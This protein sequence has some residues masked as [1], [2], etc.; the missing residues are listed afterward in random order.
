[1]SNQDAKS[2]EAINF[3]L[4]LCFQQSA[5]LKYFSP[6]HDAAIW[7]PSIQ[8]HTTSNFSNI[9]PLKFLRHFRST[10]KCAPQD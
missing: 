9:N 7:L 5:N 10:F 1:M 4:K 8:P 6:Q 2:L 3:P